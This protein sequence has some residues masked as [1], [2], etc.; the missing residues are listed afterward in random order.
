LQRRTDLSD[1]FNDQR[2]AT[3]HPVICEAQ[4]PPARALKPI[5]PRAITIKRLRIPVCPAI[6]LNDQTK[7][8]TSE[9]GR[10]GTNW[11]LTPKGKTDT[12]RPEFP[13]QHRF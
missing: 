13:P 1:F 2:Q 6:Y 10:I 12:V 8:N 11:H 7:T 9:I 5:L 4:D 3:D